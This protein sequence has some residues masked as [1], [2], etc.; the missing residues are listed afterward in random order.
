MLLNVDTAAPSGEGVALGAELEGF[1]EFTRQFPAEFRGEALSNSDRIREV[2]NSFAKSSPFSMEE[3]QRAAGEDDELYHFIAYTPID[4]ILYELDGLQDAPLSHGSCSFEE[5]PEKVVPVL[6][7]RIARYPATEIRFNLLAMVRD[8]R[9]RARE[10]GDEGLLAQEE[11]KRQGWMF[12]NALRRH[13]FVGFGAEMLKA[14]MREKVKE[15]KYEEWIEGAKRAYR[16]RVEER[17]GGGGD[18]EMAG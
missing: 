7:A 12:E 2:H 3:Q 1:K 16:G 11:G 13:N 14:V 6:Q 10:T 8:L 15:G 17:K 4:G 18:E 9:I 5:F